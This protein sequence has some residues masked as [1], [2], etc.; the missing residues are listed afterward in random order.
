MKRHVIYSIVFVFTQHIFVVYDNLLAFFWRYHPYCGTVSVEIAVFDPCRFQT[1]FQTGYQSLK[2][3]SWNTLIMYS[4]SVYFVF[5]FSCN[6]WL[7]CSGGVLSLKT[8][9]HGKV[10]VPRPGSQHDKWQLCLLHFRS[11][12][13]YFNWQ[14]VDCVEPLRWWS[15]TST[16]IPCSQTGCH[17]FQSCQKLFEY[18]TGL[19]LAS[20]ESGRMSGWKNY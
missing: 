12:T 18:N 4:T 19:I 3:T 5:V 10:S 7:H 1:R 6:N 13:I 17:I 2:S 16:S 20:E 15:K 14:A 11:N 9:G 8:D